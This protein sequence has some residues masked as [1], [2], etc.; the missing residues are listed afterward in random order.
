MGAPLEKCY[1]STFF[2][3]ENHL[4]INESNG[5]TWSECEKKEIIIKNYPS[6]ARVGGISQQIM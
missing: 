6:W 4:K 3:D 2:L 5:K 1:K